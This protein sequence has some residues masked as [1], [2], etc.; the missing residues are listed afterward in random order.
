MMEVCAVFSASCGLMPRDNRCMYMA[1]IC[2]YV[3][4]NNCGGGG[5]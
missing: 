4:C 5:L 1:H 2:F 3:R